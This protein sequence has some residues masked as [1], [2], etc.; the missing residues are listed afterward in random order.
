[1]SLVFCVCRVEVKD[2]G[3][4]LCFGELYWYSCLYNVIYCLYKVTYCSLSKCPA[5]AHWP[6]LTSDP[7]WGQEKWL[8]YQPINDNMINCTRSKSILFSYTSLKTNKQAN[9]QIKNNSNKKELLACSLVA[10]PVCLVVVAA[11]AVFGLWTGASQAGGWASV[12]VW[13]ELNASS[14]L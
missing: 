1:M 7:Q 2:G 4:V 9:K 13:P 14:R 10:V 12:I 3:G 8:T 6:P 11:S 5:W